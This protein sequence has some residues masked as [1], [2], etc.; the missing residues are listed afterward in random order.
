MIKTKIIIYLII[1]A[2]II[3]SCNS[4]LKNEKSKSSEK[5]LVKGIKIIAQPYNSRLI[6]TADLLA[7]EQLQIMAP[8]SAEVLEVYFNEGE[9]VKK[10]TSIIKLDDR[11]WK[12]ELSGVEVELLTAQ[13]DYERKKQLLEVEG[14]TQ[15]EVERLFS[16]IAVLKSKLNQLQ[17]N[18]SLANIKAP[19]SGQLGMRNFSK[20][21]FLKQGDLITTLTDYEALKV[22]F[23]IAQLHQK[24][25][26]I[27]NNVFV[28][29]DK[30]TFEAKIYAIN[31]IIDEQSKMINV[32]AKLTQA[33]PKIMPG[34]FAEV[35]LE[36][37]YIDSALLVP[38]QAI[39][40]SI[41]DQTI[42]LY[43]SGKVVKRIVSLGE[44]TS[45]KVLVYQGVNNGDTVITTGLLH[46]REG[47]DVQLNDVTF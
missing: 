13:K 26:V 11:A 9:F 12:A 16:T 8:I 15:E 37:N 31:P 24:S 22:D 7:N 35:S 46:I 47:M 14:S 17:L 10:G 43:K 1:A 38:S 29:V 33:K 25:I 6:T 44:R 3:T 39:V 28:V 42:Y 18:I 34:T 45:D 30:D 20:G 40:P 41:N 19:F 21:A 2:A 4:D 27:N 32:R 23:S 36:T 5:L